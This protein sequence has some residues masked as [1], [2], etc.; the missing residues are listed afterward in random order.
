LKHNFECDKSLTLCALY[1]TF[2]K[3]N[4]DIES[5]DSRRGEILAVTPYPKSELSLNITSVHGG[6]EVS[7]NGETN[8]SEV[9][10]DELSSTLKKANVPVAG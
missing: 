2:E 9:I 4:L 6:T 7:V 3:L 10:L 5:V 8:W 1:D